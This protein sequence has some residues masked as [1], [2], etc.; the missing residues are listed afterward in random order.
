MTTNTHRRALLATGAALAAASVLPAWAQP[1][2][3]RFAAVFTDKDIRAEM[4]QRFAKEV[5]AEFKVEPF[6]PAEG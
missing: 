3:I 1:K 2:T 5:E 6:L 4:M